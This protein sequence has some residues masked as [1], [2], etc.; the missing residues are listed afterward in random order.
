[1]KKT[2]I[3][4]PLLLLSSISVEA[5]TLNVAYAG[6]SFS[7]NYADKKK[8]GKYTNEL[9]EEKN[10]NII[11][12][13]LL[14]T[15][16]K[17]NSKNFKINFN[18]SDI[19]KGNE[20]SIVMSVS[21][22][23]EDYSREF[24]SITRTYLN[25]IINSYQILFYDFHSKKLLAAIPF[26]TE[27]QFYSKSRSSDRDIVAQLRSFYTKGLIPIDKSDGNRINIFSKVEKILNSFILKRH[28]KFKIGITKVI[29]ED[30]ALKYIPNKYSIDNNPLKILLAQQLS[31][32]LS[33]YNSIA[34][35]PYTEGVA[36]GNTMKLVFINSDIIYDI[37]LPKPDFEIIL[38]IRGFK[39]VT[40]ATSD[41]RN[42][43]LF[44]SYVRIKVI[45]KDINKVYF[46]EKIKNAS[47]II[48]PN[49]IKDIDYWRKFYFSTII[50]FE[51]FS[52]NINVLDQV[53]AKKSLSKDSSY[54]ESFI[55]L[56]KLLEKT[57]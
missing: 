47:K 35:V 37:K 26:D 27:I 38:T 42:I 19:T 22:V 34:T 48:I 46:N 56:R 4:L 30:K 44:G 29:L 23:H 33:L 24:D 51:K 20:E 41:V 31:S 5:E 55:E 10:N 15:I 45:Q 17:V 28:Y 43:Y 6:F 57:K 53:W 14:K 13:S 54:R 49:N 1:M 12:A 50:L 25:N 40:A 2:I 32:R 7:G 39:K 8:I 9:L 11:G 21:L 16:K 18:Y 36:I 3:F 52:N